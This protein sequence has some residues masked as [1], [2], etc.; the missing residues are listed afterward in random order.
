VDAIAAFM[1]LGK[2]VFVTGDHEDLGAGLCGNLPRIR[3]LRLRFNADD[4][5]PAGS[6]TRITTNSPGD[7]GGFQFADQSDQLPQKIYPRYYGTDAA[8]APHAVSDIN[9]ERSGFPGFPW[10][11]HG[12]GRAD[13]PHP[14][15]QR[16]ASLRFK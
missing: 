8:S 13:L 6:T 2:G 14:A 4:T 10:S 3:H 12:S 11:S 15:L 9:S 16:A 7:D 5:S 1:N